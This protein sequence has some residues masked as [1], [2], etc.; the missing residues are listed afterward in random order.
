M[1]WGIVPLAS[2]TWMYWRRFG[3][4]SRFA[5]D[6]NLEGYTCSMCIDTTEHWTKDYLGLD[7][8]ID[9]PFSNRWSVASAISLALVRTNNPKTSCE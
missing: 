7:K 5:L 2:S 3:G 4:T 9:L 8:T 6:G 1:L